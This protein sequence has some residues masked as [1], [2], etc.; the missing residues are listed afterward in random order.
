MSIITIR[1]NN[2][3]L[4]TQEGV[5][6]DVVSF[7]VTYPL[8][9]IPSATVEVPLGVEFITKILAN[10]IPATANAFTRGQQ[11]FLIIDVRNNL[12]VRFVG[13]LFAG[14]ISSVSF[15][16]TGSSATLTLTLTHWLNYL[17][18]C[19]VLSGSFTTTNAK[20]I[21][22]IASLHLGGAG[23][24]LSF[25]PASVLER[26]LNPE[27]LDH[28]LWGYAIYPF[29]IALVQSAKLNDTISGMSSLVP[30]VMKALT[31]FQGSML[32]LSGLDYDVKLRIMDSLL[33]LTDPSQAE[34]LLERL[35]SVTVW[36]KILE[37]A[38]KFLFSIVPHP[39]FYRV[40]PVAPGT[41][42]PWRYLYLTEIL[43]ISTSFGAASMPL[44][45]VGLYSELRPLAGG[46]LDNSNEASIPLIGGWYTNPD[47]VYGN[48]EIYRA[49]EYIAYPYE[50]AAYTRGALSYGGFLPLSR[51]PATVTPGHVLSQQAAAC[52]NS[53]GLL[54]KLAGYM[55]Y[56]KFLKERTAIITV[57]FRWDICPGSTV[58][59]QLPDENILT[60]TVL[61]VTYS[62]SV[63]GE[64]GLGPVTKYSLG[65]V[66]SYF[67]S[68]LSGHPL[69]DVYYRGGRH[70]IY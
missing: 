14:Y 25:A 38:N 67:E 70:L 47:V 56:T 30:I 11:L 42:D 8:N 18:A 32:P 37:Y 55:Y 39:L 5:Q 2:C 35:A 16:G 64:S 49:P 63:S 26:L 51:T 40:Q 23:G 41:M 6:I 22:N 45:T 53:L 61:S 3:Y 52:W 9:G 28:C 13:T 21:A 46:A 19:S 62:G 44:K 29:L 36:E 50:P 31:S 24:Y 34:A 27:G 69:Y 15:T 48:V 66:R 54:N 43:S 33:G 59:F 20:T 7:D 68:G 60:G 17:N 4:L 10:S 65:F 1:I 12:G 58:G 57:P